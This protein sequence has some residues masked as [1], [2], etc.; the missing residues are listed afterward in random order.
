MAKY[1][2]LGEGGRHVADPAVVRML[3]V[4]TGFDG[5]AI[6][7]WGVDPKDVEAGAFLR[8][9]AVCESG[10]FQPC[11]STWIEAVWISHNLKTLFQLFE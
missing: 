1:S 3:P 7:V 8:V 10:T 5:Q 6:K 2:R 9:R 4:S 11:L